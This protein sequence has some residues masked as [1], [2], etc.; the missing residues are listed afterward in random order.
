MGVLDFNPFFSSLLLMQNQN[1]LRLRK[2]LYS[3]FH[4]L[5]KAGP[6]NERCLRDGPR[7]Y[8]LKTTEEISYRVECGIIPKSE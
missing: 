2:T 4:N 6:W 5:E 7:G 8:K 3:M 1:L